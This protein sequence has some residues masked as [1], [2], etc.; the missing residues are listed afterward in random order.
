MAIPFISAL[1][2]AIKLLGKIL[3]DKPKE[4]VEKLVADV[5]SSS[6]E[7][8]AELTSERKFILDYFGRAESLPKCVQIIRSLVR[9]Y[10]TV[11]FTTT[12]V[13]WLSVT[14]ELPDPWFCW[15]TAGMLGWWFG[16]RTAEHWQNKKIK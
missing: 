8:Q 6:P 1:P 4:I 10:I 11:L 12:L 9:P 3:P 2:L 14:G 7:I 13:V 5:V 16:S 15:A